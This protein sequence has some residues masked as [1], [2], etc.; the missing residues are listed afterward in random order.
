LIIQSL[1]LVNFRNIKK[2]TL[3]FSGTFNVIRGRNAQGKTNLLEAIHLFSLGRSFRTRRREEMVRFDEEYL[4]A[5]LGCKSDAGVSFRIDIGLERGG[6][7]SVSVNGKKLAALSEIIGIMP[8]VIFTPEDVALATGPPS[9]RRTFV[10]YTASQISPSF[11][12]NL[13]EYRRVLVQR[14]AALKGAMESGR[15]PEGI[16]AWDEMITE[17]GAAIIEGRKEMLAEIESRS[18]RLIN[19]I[20]TVTG[21]ITMQYSCS[22]EP[23]GAATKEDLSEALART[24]EQERRRGYTLVGPH[25]DDIRIFLDDRELKRY[26][27]QGRK[28]LASIVLKLAQAWAIMERRAERPIVLL[29]DIF[30]ELDDET[31]GRVNG[32]LSDRYQSFITTPRSEDFIDVEAA[33]FTVEE[34]VVTTD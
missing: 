14:N 4:F 30:S 13:K 15:P 28:R 7:M 10:D 25:Y 1:D 12:Q 33:R 6:R 27:S 8:T 3:A 16:K 20:M 5:R 17:S 2:A 29:D 24:R 31:A 26:G 9:E 23:S 11:L 22:F 34:G 18:S 19:D 21:S 32:L